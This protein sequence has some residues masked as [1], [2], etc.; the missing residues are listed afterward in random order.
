M[1]ELT[2]DELDDLLHEATVAACEVLD[3][4]FPGFEKGGITSDFAY[5]LEHSIRKL[6]VKEGLLSEEDNN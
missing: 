1:T 3:V 5:E 4:E 2:P 6:L